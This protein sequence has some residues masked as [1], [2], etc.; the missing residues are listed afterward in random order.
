MDELERNRGHQDEKPKRVLALNLDQYVLIHVIESAARCLQVLY[1]ESPSG[2]AD[3]R[4]SLSSLKKMLTDRHTELGTLC[5][6]AERQ[7]LDR[8]VIKCVDAKMN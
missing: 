7:K 8:W 6:D 2:C 4:E 3:M 5:N 1:F